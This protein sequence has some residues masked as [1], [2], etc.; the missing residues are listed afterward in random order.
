MIKGRQII[1]AS[2]PS[3]SALKISSPVRIPP[4]TMMVVRPLTASTISGSTSAVAGVSAKARPPWFDTMIAAAPAWTAFSA[5][6]A[7]MIPFTTK[8]ISA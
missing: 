7:V 2:A 5:L 8:G 1:T 3:A 6:F 4:S